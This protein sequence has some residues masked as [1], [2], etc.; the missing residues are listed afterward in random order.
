MKKQYKNNS[1]ILESIHKSVTRSYKNGIINLTAMQKFDKLC[2][3]DGI[4]IVKNQT[5][6]QQVAG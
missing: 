1:S 5:Q 4:H 3:V 6:K 2:M